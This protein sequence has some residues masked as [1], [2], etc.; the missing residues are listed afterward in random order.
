MARGKH[1]APEDQK[2]GINFFKIWAVIF[3]VISAAFIGMLVY[4][5]M[6]TTGLLIGIS[7][8]VVLIAAVTAFILF[9][10]S[11][12]RGGKIAALIISILFTAC[13]IFGI[14]YIGNTMTFLDNITDS[15][16]KITE[17]HV[18]V[19]DDSKY[20]KIDDI[21]GRTV[22]TLKSSDSEYDEAKG[23]LKK[24][25][26]VKFKA[27]SNIN[28]ICESVLEKNNIAFISAANHD[29]AKE[30]VD[31]YNKGTRIL[32]SV[33]VKSTQ[34]NIV[35]KTD[36]TK[37]PFNV[38]IS[39][40]DTEG[41][42]A[43]T[44]RSDV[45]MILTIDPVKHKILMTSIPRDSYVPLQCDGRKGQMDKFTHTGI[46]GIEETVATAEAL[47][48]VEINYYVKV[49]FTTVRELIDILGGI[50]VYSEYGFTS[51]DGITYAEGL[52]YLT[53]NEAL[54]FARERKA[55]S[56]GDFQRNRNQQI[57][58]EGVIN[59][60]TSSTAIL[61]SYTDILK[62]IENYMATNMSAKD[63][64]K[65]VK[66]QLG[67]MTGWELE[68]SAVTG[69]TGSSPCYSHGGAYASVVYPDENSVAE[70]GEK[71]RS[72]GKQ[73]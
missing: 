51:V 19:K 41:S 5:N 66:M 9:R 21:D 38:Y 15:D 64:Q 16:E 58:V 52:N 60:V 27:E 46:Y 57:V 6:L 44:S 2:S 32:Y 68:S 37:N 26:D 17:Y 34:K 33:K 10:N 56:N 4:M 43:S 7:A 18:I 61:T 12:G 70:A 39:G 72:Y 45:N 23:K 35:K 71:I 73:E 25:V 67:N 36:V 49:N 31:G 1:F 65:L 29:T 14:Y 30:I 55:F 11:K 54:S 20:K 3:L 47:L 50:E 28:S 24:E 53:G 63:I 62:T 48:G 40:I 42:I 13:Y 59:K 69:T 22:K 8:V